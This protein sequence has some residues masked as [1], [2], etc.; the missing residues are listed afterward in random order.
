MLLFKKSFLFFPFWKE[1]PVKIEISEEFILFAELA[2]KTCRIF[3]FPIIK[4]PWPS[5]PELSVSPSA[6]HT[7]KIFIVYER[8]RQCFSY[9]LHSDSRTSQ[10]LSKGA[11]CMA[12]KNWAKSARH[13]MR[14]EESVRQ[15]VTDPHHPS[16][17]HPTSA[18]WTPRSSFE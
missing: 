11:V 13:A 7:N 6:E 16:A 4:L 14:G 10:E 2:V 9:H 8:H 18:A 17:P 3:C 15:T 5:P 12:F 1:T